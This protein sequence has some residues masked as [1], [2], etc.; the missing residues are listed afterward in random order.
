VGQFYRYSLVGQVSSICVFYC[1]SQINRRVPAQHFFRNA[2]ANPEKNPFKLLPLA[3]VKP[4]YEDSE[5]ERESICA[6]AT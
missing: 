5:R 1:T 3:V 4:K 2:L 6:A